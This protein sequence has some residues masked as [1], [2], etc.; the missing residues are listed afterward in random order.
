MID[1]TSKNDLD[2]LCDDE[3][4]QGDQRVMEVE[5][6]GVEESWDVGND[7]Y[8]QQ[9]YNQHQQQIIKQTP[10]QPTTTIKHE[11]NILTESIV[12][13]IMTRNLDND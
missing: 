13:P 2:E 6:W 9:Q 12:R 1:C 3:W 11:R 4:S 5:D 10:Q 8:Q 7:K